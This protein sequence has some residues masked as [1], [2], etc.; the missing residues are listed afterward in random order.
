MLLFYAGHGYLLDD[1]KMGYWIPID[2][3]VK[4]AAGWI[5]SSNSS[6]SF[7]VMNSNTIFRLLFKNYFVLFNLS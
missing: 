1:T 6:S 2:A 5:T 7:F 4:T 3:S